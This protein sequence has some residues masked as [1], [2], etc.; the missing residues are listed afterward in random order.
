MARGS[1]IRY[2]QFYTDGS[3][4]RQLE[5]KTQPK[6]KLQQPRPRRRK[7]IVLRVDFVAV[8]GMLVTGIMLLMMLSGM[9]SLNKI[10]GEVTRLEGYLAELEQE[11]LELHQTYRAGYDIEQ[12]REE[13]LAMGMIPASRARTVSLDVG[14]GE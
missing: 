5:V 14:D 10:N 3:A 4:A 8:A 2:V 7:K 9:A 1:E 6:K 13:A 12:I 11:N